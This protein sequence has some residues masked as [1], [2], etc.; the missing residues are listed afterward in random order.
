MNERLR[1]S[2]TIQH[3]LREFISFVLRRPGPE[4]W[5]F[6]GGIALLV[7]LNSLNLD[8]KYDGPIGDKPASLRF[9]LSGLIPPIAYW[10]LTLVAVLLIVGAVGWA[11]HRYSSELK[12][13]SR[14][15]V[16][17]IEGRGLRDD[18]GSP[19]AA[20]ISED[21]EGIR[22]P[23]IVDIRQR[24]D[25]TLLEPEDLL[26][27]VP[28]MLTW[29]NQMKACT[30]RTDLTVVYGGITAVPFT[31]LTGVL[32]DDE[33]SIVTMDWDR[34][35]E[36]WRSLDGQ[37][38]NLRFAIDGL[39]Q[40]G[41]SPEVVLAV[42]VSYA[43]KAEDLSSAFDYPIVR[44]TLPDFTSSHWSQAKQAALADQMFS[45]LKQLDGAG[46]KQ[47]HMVLAAQNSVAFSLGRRYEKRNLP[48]VTVYQF[49]RS[50]PLKY[51]WGIQMPVCGIRE[52]SIVHT[53]AAQC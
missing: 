53:R 29:L 7:V 2:D 32:L 16:F 36:R 46:V 24:K 40:I 50:Q 37:D 28:P 8:F 13:L 21:I 11:W 17:V 38:D 43:V 20:A 10:G 1:W 9:A 27:K 49:E 51:P 26:K 25:G 48:R 6:A 33:G 15:K 30:D 47:V 52:P 45:V 12:R 18:D 39:D 5:I 22:L 35:A 23:Y 14:K 3:G 4:K 41:S 31:F 19:L 44:M 34:S 42:S